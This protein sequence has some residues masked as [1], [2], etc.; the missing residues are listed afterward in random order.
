MLGLAALTLGLVV[1]AGAAG[2]ASGSIVPTA[3]QAQNPFTA[4]IPF[5]SGQSINVVIPANS[6]FA[7]PN[8]HAGINIVECA[9]P[10]GVVPTQTSACDGPTIQGSTILPATDGSFT[11]PNYQV[12]ALPDSI[13]LGE[14]TTGPT[15][16]QTAATECMLYIGNDQGD[17]TKP[18][19]WSAPFFIAPNATD[20][21]SPA[22]DGSP[23]AVPTKPSSALST[24]VASPTTATADGVDFSKVTVTL[25]ATG[26]VPV[27]GKAVTLTPTSGAAKVTGPSPAL[28]D[29][30]GQT[31]FSVTDTTAQAVTLTAVD[32]TDSVT[33]TQQ[34]NVTFQ[35]PIVDPSHSTVSANP[36][37]VTAGNSTTIMVTLRD[38]GGTPQPVANQT[39]TLAGTGSA[40]IIPTANPNVTNASGVVTF[41]ATDT[42]AETV[43]FTA[44][45]TTET[46]VIA[47]TASVTFGTPSVSA[48]L[49]SV[50]AS[51]PAPV[52]A[53]GTSVVVTLLSP[54]AFPVA[55]KTVSLSSTGSAVV[56]APTPATTGANGTV[57]FPLTDTVP[58]TVTLTATDTSD[59]IIL[60]STP[61][62]T[63][64]AGSP[65]ATTSTVVASAT[66]SPADGQTQ[67]LITVTVKDQFG[68]PLSGKT[69]AIQSAPSGVLVHP[70]AVGGT[71]TP[72]ITDSSGT[73]EFEVT[74]THAESVTFIA[75]DT[76]D[77]LVL[78]MTVSIAYLPGPA[79]PTAVGTTVAVAPANPPADGSTPST[80]T[81]T[82]TDYFSNP[83]A[84]KTIAL[85][86][87]NGKSTIVPVS[88]VTNA[89]G[90]ATFHVT[91]STAEVVTYQATDVTDASAVLAHKGV[92]TFGN[93]NGPPCDGGTLRTNSNGT[94]S[95]AYLYTGGE[96]TFSVPGGDSSITASVV[97]AS[98]GGGAPGA[99]I[100]GNVAVTP[101]STLYVEVGGLP[102]N[103]GGTSYSGDGG[104]ASDIQ[105]QSMGTAATGAN[106]ANWASALGS[107]LIVA[108]GG[109]GPG[110]AAPSNQDSGYAG[111]SGVGG[112]GGQS[113]QDGQSV[114]GATCE[115]NTYHCTPVTYPGGPGGLPGENVSPVGNGQGASVANPGGFFNPPV[116]AYSLGGAGGGGYTGGA[117]GTSGSAGPSNAGGFYTYDEAG[118]GGGG[119]GSSFVGGEETV[120][121]PAAVGAPAEVIITY[122]PGADPPA[123]TPEVPTVMMLPTAGV[124][125]LGGWFFV[126][127]RRRSK[128]AVETP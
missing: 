26:A 68:Q 55:G 11:Y 87:L 75:T 32:T 12:Y 31:T 111:T 112:A 40:V 95:C 121:S 51:T 23:P 94:A 4:G 29:A 10:D 70:V 3:A 114:T 99:S 48:S 49:S 69:L 93:L 46:T 16:G 20:S 64:A 2:P 15:C 104:G 27:A 77:N 72:G 125:V 34:P 5:A 59:N 71:S 18:H 6:A 19:L 126:A 101:G 57:S 127:R 17:F 128:E 117:A 119:G 1:S 92:V 33:V 52:G 37:T 76:T 65:S 45:D 90:Q 67:T 96:Q 39:V 56:G 106:G 25:V 44:T 83:I 63:F 103:G 73:A 78:S 50:T 105:T 41:T 120:G 109:G 124:L 115:V 79:D 36:T 62:V 80:I 35:A 86:A 61:S 85:S 113:G 100:S 53:Q 74:D 42:A 21:G 38:Q 14:G 84:G 108:G 7:A 30:N 102:F 81:V 22:G 107:R 116:T 13:T 89:A 97:G 24:A 82:L 28:T 98:G 8:D 88:P 60:A 66:T 58:E 43:K 54:T 118:A 123:V 91:D 122:V 9:A 47:N 110:G